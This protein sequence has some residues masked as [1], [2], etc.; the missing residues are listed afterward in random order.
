[1]Q[2]ENVKLDIDVTYS[3]TA[4][5]RG[6]H[7]HYCRGLILPILGGQDRAGQY[8]WANIPVEGGTRAAHIGCTIKQQ[9]ART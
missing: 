2:A 3:V 8:R 4:P 6:R 5:T 1:M 7:C 9:T